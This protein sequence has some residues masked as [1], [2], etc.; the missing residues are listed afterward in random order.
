M[1][2][3]FKAL[4]VESSMWWVH[5]LVCQKKP[6]WVRVVDDLGSFDDVDE[7]R[8]EFKKRGMSLQDLVVEC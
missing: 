1:K 7:A 4:V 8:Q 2:S 6:K 5:P 3:K